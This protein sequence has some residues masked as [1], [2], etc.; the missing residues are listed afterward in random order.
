MRQSI[1]GHAALASKPHPQETLT[2]A[3]RDP[4]SSEAVPGLSTEPSAEDTEDT[5]A[6]AI[7]ASPA[8]VSVSA[9]EVSAVQAQQAG[10]RQT[11]DDASAQAAASP[12][13]AVTTDKQGVTIVYLLVVTNLLILFSAAL[14]IVWALSRDK[15]TQKKE[16]HERVAFQEEDFLPEGA[17]HD[18]S[19]ITGQDTYEL[20][21]SIILIGRAHPTPESNIQH[22]VIDEPA[23]GRRHAVIQRKRNGYWLIDQNS[24]NGTFVNDQRITDA[25]CLSHGDRVRFYNFE[26]EFSLAGMSLG[27]ETVM[28]GSLKLASDNVSLAGDTTISSKVNESQIDLTVPKGLD[29][30][31][32]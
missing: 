1:G 28:V 23:I 5:K 16:V 13:P 8:A 14:A 7:P 32:S 12:A 31:R 30:T 6:P 22:V 9:D 19:G 27:V 29:S 4:K 20:N 24:K 2:T 3:E 18:L 10:P 21:N 15:K 17:L 25:V 26:F 11:V